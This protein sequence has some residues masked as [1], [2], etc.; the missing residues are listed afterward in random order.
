MISLEEVTGA[1]SAADLQTQSYGYGMN[2]LLQN[3]YNSKR[4]G[5]VLLV[6]KPGYV[7]NLDPRITMQK[8]KGTT[9]GSGYAYDTHVPMLWFGKSIPTGQSLRKVSV[10]DIA[11]S[12][13]QMLNI[14][15]PSGTTGEPLI[16]LFE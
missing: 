5:D 12:I 4:S 14:Q 7:Q 10:T 8:I 15:Y 3:G 2:Q 16:E 1:L 13:A 6:F 11:P 9:H